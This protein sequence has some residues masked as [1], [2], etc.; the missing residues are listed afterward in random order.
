VQAPEGLMLVDAAKYGDVE[1]PVFCYEPK[2]GQ[3]VGACRMCLVEIEGIPKLQ[4][5]CST[6]VKDGM[7]VH[8]QTQRVHWAQN[9]IVEF[10]LLNH[11][12]DCPVCD[13]GGEC[14]LQDISYGWG[15]G[16]SRFIEP[17]R[18]FVKPLELS[19]LI[20]ID[21]ERCILCYRCVRFSQELSEDYQLV[22]HDRGAATF[23]GTFDGHPYVAPFSG[24]IIELCPVGALTSI[25]YRFRARPWDIE[26]AGTVCTLCPAQCN[27]ELTVRDERVLRVLS[28]DHAEVDDGWLCD[29][30]RFAYQYTHSD[31]RL[32]QPLV[33][34]G[35][36]LLPASW[37]KALDHAAKLLKAAGARASALAGGETTNEE[38]FLL[39]GLLRDHLGAGSLSARPG[40]EQGLDVLRALAEP[41]LQAS[42][43]D[44]EFAHT[45][46]LL[47]C[48]PIDDAPILDLRLRKGI[49]RHGT[50]LVVASARPTAL[51]PSAVATLRYAPGAGEAF[52][53]ALDAALA[54]D[55][56]NLGGA[57]SAAGTSAGAVRELLDALRAA[58]EEIVIVYGERLLRGEA[59]K[60]LLNVASRLGLRGISGAG[61]LELPSST[62]GRGLR[63]AGFAPG[64]GPGYASL[65]QP[66]RDALGIAE[67]LAEGELH[68]VWLHHADP[69]RSHPD[70]ALWERALH[71]AQGVIAVDTVLTDTMAEHADVVFPAEAYAEKEGTLTHPDGRVQRL[72]PAI[73][74]PRGGHGVRALWQVI[75]DIAGRLGYDEGVMLTGA[76]ASQRL[77]AAV[78]FYEGLTLDEIGGRGIRWPE[79]GPFVS[80][81]WEL[82]T[83][84]VPAGAPAARDGAL[85]L[86]T[87]RSLWAAKEVEASPALHFLRPQQ[88]V[89]LSPVDAD[90]LGIREGDRVELAQGPV[91][92][93]GEAG[94]GDGMRTRVRGP[95]RLRAAIPAGSVFLAE[96]THADPANALT[97]R[98]VEVR[99]VG[100]APELHDPA[101]AVQATPGIE[102]R[103]EM[104][105][106]AGLPIPPREVT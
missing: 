94:Q 63:E 64:H 1:I 17:K 96:G 19:P 55:D 61:L 88:V 38:A 5:A 12:L 13:K 31:Q 49:R 8:T 51:D 20:A 26:G 65:A 6:P 99:R 24:N 18:H 14:P 15:S 95:V 36:E 76:I 57:A 62:N 74:R 28:R 78:P 54:G 45:V 92:G 10:L 81:E 34:E 52:L 50:K 70:R 43:P 85:R 86:G 101:L 98:T 67:G 100:G 39:Q 93:A 46:L 53:V 90:A 69:L 84:E 59:G 47:D 104:P 3:P 40:G 42:V 27:V 29:K 80:P 32:V 9:A 106:S 16:T 91:A 60:A 41:G 72:R 79:R 48:D 97:E 102:G 2:L 30:G 75:S 105:P 33:R 56:G 103:S 22:L 89:E 77:F 82:A 11:P 58:G 23:V 73:G 66:A 37:E 21:R 83:L 7:V 68:T 4:T 71:T 25:A 44:L 35:T 87:F